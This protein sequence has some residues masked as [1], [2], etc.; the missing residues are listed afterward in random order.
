MDQKNGGEPAQS[1]I[2]KNR[3]VHRRRM[4]YISLTA[5]IV[6][7]YFCLFKVSE[8]RLNSISEIM[9]WFYISMGSVVGAY[10][11]FRTLDDKWQKKDE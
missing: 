8:T 1:K 7:T 5:I 11:G 9:T 6:A 2:I 4:A 10:V 3:W